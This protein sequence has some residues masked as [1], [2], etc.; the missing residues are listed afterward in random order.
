MQSA[1]REVAK[2]LDKTDPLAD[3]EEIN[4]HKLV[5]YMCPPND[6]FCGCEVMFV[7]TA[8]FDRKNGRVTE[9]ILTN[10]EGF[11]YS[12]KKEKRLKFFKI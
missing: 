2:I 4:F 12:I 8:F 1:S 11:V 10:K 5:Q 9:M 6:Q 7:D 3:I